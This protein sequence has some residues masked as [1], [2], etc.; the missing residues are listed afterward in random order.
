MSTLVAAPL[1]FGAALASTELSP[2]ATCR[3]QIRSIDDQAD[4]DVRDVNRL[5]A[6]LENEVGDSA[7]ASGGPDVL[8]R[9]HV[10]LDAAKTRRSEIIDKQHDDLN[11]IRARCDR[12]RV[13]SGE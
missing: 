8:D 3:E 5:I 7:I 13:S 2:G 1:L 6:L 10:K 11:A 9:L 4:T 12:S